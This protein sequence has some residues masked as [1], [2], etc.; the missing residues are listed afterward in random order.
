MRRRHSAIRAV[1][2]AAAVVAVDIVAIPLCKL[3]AATTIDELVV[4]SY[5]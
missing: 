5:Q 4:S 1:E 3:P 2:N